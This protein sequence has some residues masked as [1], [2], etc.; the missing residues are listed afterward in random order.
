ML[1]GGPTA[2]RSGLNAVDVKTDEVND[3]SADDIKG[4][5]P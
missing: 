4:V 1:P 3:D 5:E 2:K